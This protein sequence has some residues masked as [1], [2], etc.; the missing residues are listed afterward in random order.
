LCRY[1]EDDEGDDE[2]F[3]EVAEVGHAT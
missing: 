2:I 3:S 1:D